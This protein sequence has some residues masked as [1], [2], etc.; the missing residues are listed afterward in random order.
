[1]TDVLLREDLLLRRLKSLELDEVLGAFL[2]NITK[3]IDKENF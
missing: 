1:L 2:E 3:K